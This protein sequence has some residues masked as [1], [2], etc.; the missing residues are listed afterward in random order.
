M[1]CT[2]CDALVEV[3]NAGVI[4]AGQLDPVRDGALFSLSARQNFAT[5]YARS[6]LFGAWF[7]G[8]AISAESLPWISEFDRRDVAPDNQDLLDLFSSLSTARASAER[9][10]TGLQ[11]TPGAAA[12]PD[13][14]RAALFAGYSYLLMAEN[15][16][17]GAADGGPP[18]APADLLQRA[19]H[20]F[21]L[22]LGIEESALGRVGR[23]RARL[24][25]G[26]R[27]AARDDALRVPVG[28]SYSLAYSDDPGQ[29][30]R[31][32]NTIWFATRA[33]GALS[34][35]PAFRNL[36]DPRV[37]VAPPA[38]ALPPIDGVTPLWTQGKYP[39]YAAPIRLASR[40]EADYIVAEIDGGAAALALIQRQRAA[41]GQPAYAGPTDGDS[42]L[43]EL[44]LQRSRDFFLEGKRVGDLRRHPALMSDLPVTGQPY[45]K[46]GF[47]PIGSQTC[48]PLPAKET[49]PSRG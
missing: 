36:R 45:H 12:N 47:A 22:A 4:D 3:D 8:E 9:V 39:S 41:H 44:L 10:V 18:L 24:Q 15:F 38:D 34:V 33:R 5:A 13:L 20:F 46:S 42:L 27:G 26:D 29:R 31:L 43:R 23:A 6:I 2:A 21:S 48:Y 37:P 32:G 14:A 49:R 30:A 1:L 19:V 7:S 40:L 35:A 17:L 11:H 28:F 25:A 16:C